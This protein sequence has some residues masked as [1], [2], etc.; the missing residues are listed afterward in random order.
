MLK[1]KG[2]FQITMMPLDLG[3]TAS[4][5]TID[6]TFAG[7]LVGTGHGHMLAHTTETEGSAGY[8]AMEMVEVALGDRTGGFALQHS[9]TMTQGEATALV[10]IVPD[11]GSGGLEGI[12]GELTIEVV[13]GAHHYELRYQL[14]S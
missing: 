4:G 3:P 6:K 7:D 9:G 5:F 10:S 1:A 12:S 14:T 11:S 8:V 2:T 13:D